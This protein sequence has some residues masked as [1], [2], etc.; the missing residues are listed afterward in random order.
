VYVRWVVWQHDEDS[1]Q[2]RG[3]VQAAYDLR[4]RGDLHPAERAE[5]QGALEWLGDC[6]EAPDDDVELAERAIFWFR[7]SAWGHRRVMW[8]LARLLEA[9][10][11]PVELLISPWPGHIVWS[12]RDQVA[13]IP[14]RRR[15]LRRMRRRR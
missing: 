14:H 5:L 4:N 1:R 11:I 9:H 12:D 3:I 13:A 15:A 7:D 6:L 10:G 2:P 8:T